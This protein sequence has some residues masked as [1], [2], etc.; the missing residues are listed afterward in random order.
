MIVVQDR[1]LFR[2]ARNAYIHKV[3]PKVSLR[4]V[5]LLRDDAAISFLNLR[6]INS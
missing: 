6:N 3:E 1:K 4:G 2:F 5:P